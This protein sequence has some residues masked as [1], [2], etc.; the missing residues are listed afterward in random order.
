MASRTQAKLENAGSLHRGL[1]AGGS[2]RFMAVEAKGLC[3]LV[4]SH[5][6]L[7]PSA[8]RLAGEAMLSALVMS[9]YIK[10]EERISLQLQGE[11]P[12]CAFI[13]DVDSTGGARARFSPHSLLYKTGSPVN[14]IMLAI[15]F[16]SNKE[17]YRGIT[18]VDQT[19]IEHALSEHLQNSTQVDILLR[20]K[21][22]V[23]KKGQIRFAGGLL[24]ERLPDSKEHPSISSEEFKR[25]FAHLDAQPVEDILVG[26]AFGKLGSTPIQ[27][28]ENRG[29]Q[30]RCSC[31]QERVE[32]VLFNMGPAELREMWDQD[33]GAEVSCHFCAVSY[34]VSKDRLAELIAIHEAPT[35]N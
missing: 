25:H 13:A 24:L 18:K 26:L 17:L 19:T 29:L 30:W 8:S 23:D 21:V 1:C 32:A 27:L 31:G 16:D 2:V 7:N 10:G 28:L 15:K 35:E 33:G 14:G 34:G 4:Q 11:S 6:E 20:L 3:R 22:Q 12:H 9:A 5:H